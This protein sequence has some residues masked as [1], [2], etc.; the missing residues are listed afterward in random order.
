MAEQYLTDKIANAGRTAETLAAAVAPRT[1][2]LY[3]DGS[4]TQAGNVYTERSILALDVNTYLT[5]V[6]SSNCAALD[7]ACEAVVAE[8]VDDLVPAMYLIASREAAVDTVGATATTDLL[9]FLYSFPPASDIVAV[10]ATLF[11]NIGLAPTSAVTYHTANAAYTQTSAI[12]GN[13]DLASNWFGAYQSY[14]A[15]IEYDD[16]NRNGHFDSGEALQTY[17]LGTRAWNSQAL[18]THTTSGG[19]RVFVATSATADNVVT[20][21]CTTASSVIVDPSSQL[22]TP[23]ATKCSVVISN[24][25]FSVYAMHILIGPKKR[26][27]RAR[28]HIGR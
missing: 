12:S 8:L 13:L 15:I 14:E 25:P 21:T 5:G 16:S 20:I 23:N 1:A 2:G 6:L 10:L 26:G 28:N 17:N 18:Q 7:V 9:A 24:F 27:R 19:G 11:G 3:T 22:L 4:L